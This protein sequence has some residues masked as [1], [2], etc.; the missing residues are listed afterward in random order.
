[1][2]AKIDELTQEYKNKM[3]AGDLQPDHFLARQMATI[4]ICHV[5]LIENDVKPSLAFAFS[6]ESDD[7]YEGFIS[8]WVTD[9]QQL[10]QDADSDE[11]D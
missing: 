3:V 6:M 8:C 10:I 1:M 11:D 2:D 9:L 7:A 4:W 5:T